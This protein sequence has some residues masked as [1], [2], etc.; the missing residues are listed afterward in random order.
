MGCGPTHANPKPKKRGAALCSSVVGTV[1][2]T[3]LHTQPFF[4]LGD[5][6]LLAC[7]P[8][9]APNPEHMLTLL[10]CCA[11]C[12]WKLCSRAAS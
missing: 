6:P 2:H 10:G 1:L 5:L 7:G 3:E 9:R 12:C 4:M 8:T 11:F